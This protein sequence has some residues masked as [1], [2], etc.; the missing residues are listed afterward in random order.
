[1]ASGKSDIILELERMILPLQGLQLPCKENSDMRLHWGPI[2]SHFPHHAFPTAAIHEFL[3]TA[4][5]TAASTT[6]FMA[7]ILAALM[8]EKGVTLWITRTGNIFPPG[9]LAFGVEPDRLLILTVRNEKEA[10]WAM[11]ES[12]KCA[13]LTAVVGEIREISFLASRRLQLAVEQSKVTGFLLRHQPK[14]IQPI[15][16]VARWRIQ[17]LPGLAPDE[18]PGLGFPKWS[19]ELERIRNGRTGKWEI[20][21]IDRQFVFE[22]ESIDRLKD[23]GDSRARGWSIA[24][25]DTWKRKTG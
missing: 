16:A 13:S 1:M 7:A 24:T 21:W 11:E 25:S 18:M 20:T 15:A 2:A 3:C 17:P 8:L 6:G 14:Q 22:N 4:P 10:L 12:L 5:E 19:V 23:S 9:L